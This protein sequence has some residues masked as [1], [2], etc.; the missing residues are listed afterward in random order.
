MSSLISRNSAASSGATGKD[1]PASA[2]CITVVP[3]PIAAWGSGA[4]SC[5]LSAAAISTHKA[6]RPGGGRLRTGGAECSPSNPGPS[7]TAAGPPPPDGCP[8]PPGSRQGPAAIGSPRSAARYVISRSNRDMCDVIRRELGEEREGRE[9]G[10]EDEEG[11]EREE[12]ACTRGSVEISPSPSSTDPSC[13]SRAP[14]AR[15]SASSNRSWAFSAPYN[16]SGPHMRRQNKHCGA[17]PLSSP[18]EQRE[19]EGRSETHRGLKRRPQLR[20]PGSE[21]S[22]GFPPHRSLARQSRHTVPQWEYQPHRPAHKPTG[23]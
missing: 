4:S 16:S 5:Q 6:S 7:T 19:L 10:E 18:T 2:R 21:R 20:R 13:S 12:R 3:G 15:S 8:D 22:F 1:T 14:L 17:A 23:L 9:E 11:E